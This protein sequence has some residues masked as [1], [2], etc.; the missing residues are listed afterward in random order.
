MANLTAPRKST[1]VSHE[2]FKIIVEAKGLNLLNQAKSTTKELQSANKNALKIAKETAKI[3]IKEA[4]ESRNLNASKLLMKWLDDTQSKTALEK[5][6]KNNID[7]ITPL[8]NDVNKVHGS[9]IQM[10]QVNKQLFKFGHFHELNKVD[11]DGVIIENK[12]V[13]SMKFFAT[14]SNS[15]LSRFAKYGENMDKFN[16]DSKKATERYL[17][18]KYETFVKN[19]GLKIG[20]DKVSKIVND[21]IA[22]KPKATKQY[23]VNKIIDALEASKVD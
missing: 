1:K 15:L 19:A 3:E 2:D 22:K 11:F 4:K 9:N 18:S 20:A 10:N 7:F 21:T 8:L 14:A 13:F 16:I 23:I 17:Q 6:V 12:I 5:Y